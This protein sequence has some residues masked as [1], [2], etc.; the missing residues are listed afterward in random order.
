MRPVA[1]S[2]AAVATR[3]GSQMSAAEGNRPKVATILVVEDDEAVRQT[4]VELLRSE[5]YGVIEAVDGIEGLQRLKEESIDVVLLDLH[6]PRL[7]GLGVLD[8]M[9]DPPIVIVLSAFEYF[10]E[11]SMHSRFE[12]KVFAFLQK[13]IPPIRLL[14]VVSDA[15][16]GNAGRSGR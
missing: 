16:S 12:S 3:A 15:L 11:D 7:D 10:D 2:G 9:E 4:T 8:A 14:S 13:P 6:L 1:D 5:G